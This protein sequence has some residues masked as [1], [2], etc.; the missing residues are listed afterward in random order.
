MSQEGK[1]TE[2]NFHHYGLRSKLR[3]LIGVDA[4]LWREGETS[5]SRHDLAGTSAHD[6]EIVV[7]SYG[8]ERGGGEEKEGS[9]SK[10][11]SERGAGDSKS[12]HQQRGTWELE[13]VEQ[14]IIKDTDADRPYGWRED[15]DQYGQVRHID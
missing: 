15:L 9:K 2:D 10:E 6:K 5:L 3:A 8:E 13:E 4:A 7:E 12:K 14:G 1:S 11:D